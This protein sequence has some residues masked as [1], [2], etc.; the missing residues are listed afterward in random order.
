MEIGL[1]L[2]SRDYILV[3]CRLDV[4]NFQIFLA[5]RKVSSSTVNQLFHIILWLASKSIIVAS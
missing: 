1:R 5:I 2:H 3:V 4:T